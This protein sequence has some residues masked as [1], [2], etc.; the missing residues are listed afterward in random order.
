MCISKAVKKL[1]GIGFIVDALFDNFAYPYS[2][3]TVVERHT[4][5][6]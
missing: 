1:S 6:V 5:F 3:Y 4:N 2:L